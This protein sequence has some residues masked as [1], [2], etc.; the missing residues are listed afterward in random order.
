MF[1][2]SRLV[3]AE[4][5]DRSTEV[6]LLLQD[7]DVLSLYVRSMQDDYNNTEE[8]EQSW[9]KDLGLLCTLHQITNALN[10]SL[11]INAV[12]RL[13]QFHYIHT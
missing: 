2:Q 6:Y 5:I 12:I 1:A 11:T 13:R 4:G 10:V 8:E 7:K 3:D 9:M